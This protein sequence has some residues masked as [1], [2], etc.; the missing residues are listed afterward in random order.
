MC[1]VLAPEA[2]HS[3]THT[4]DAT[5]QQH[6]PLITLATCSTASTCRCQRQCKQACDSLYPVDQS[7]RVPNPGL[8]PCLYP[9][10]LGPA[11]E[12]VS[13]TSDA[14]CS[15]LLFQTCD[16]TASYV[17]ITI[18][19]IRIGDAL[20]PRPVQGLHVL[21]AL[22]PVRYGMYLLLLAC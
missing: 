16:S 20:Q 18:S 17:F 5:R 22:N 7:R 15:A 19:I 8:C 11:F 2:Q 6:H 10:L 3:T 14:K 4:T 13:A 21:L 1:E 12:Q 9:P